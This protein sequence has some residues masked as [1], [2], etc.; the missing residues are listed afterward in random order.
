MS[1]EMTKEEIK[2]FLR[3]EIEN[4]W[5][6][7]RDCREMVEMYQKQDDLTE[8]EAK[9]YEIFKDE[10]ASTIKETIM[11]ENLFRTFFKINYDEVE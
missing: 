2:D 11:L 6:H 7:V 10:K 3:K 4:N 5:K 8:V 1:R 9:C